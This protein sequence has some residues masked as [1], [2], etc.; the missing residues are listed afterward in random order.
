MELS[1]A[2]CEDLPDER[3]SLA[4]MVESFFRERPE[5]CR[6]SV[7]SSG[8]EL[9]SLFRAGRYQIIFLD[10]YMPGLSGMD[11]A[12]AVRKADRNC[13]I[14]FATTSH[15]HGMDSFEVQAADYLVKPFRQEDVCEALD[16]CISQHARTMRCLQ[17]LSEWEQVDIP[18]QSLRYIEI[19]GHQA[20]LH[21]QDQVISTRRSL[22]DLESA[23][24]SS[25]FIRCHRSFL[26]N[27]DYIT[28]IQGKD[29]CL[30][31]GVRV[32]IG[33]SSAAQVKRAFSDWLFTRDW[34][35]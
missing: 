35:R 22:D 31:D 19:Q 18:L 5:K 10:I 33:P 28:G 23:I 1:I 30:E 12:R 13:A 16:W 6:L 25:D 34:G 20:Q 32:P 4:H 14:V 11:T 24:N 15:S 3:I 21:T 8:E 7:F 17:V 26:V 29:L 2:I 27:M 9:L